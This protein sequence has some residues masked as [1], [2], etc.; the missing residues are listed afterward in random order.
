MTT[1]CSDPAGYPTVPGI[2]ATIAG[3]MLPQS[4][5][6]DHA[7]HCAIVG[8]S[9]GGFPPEAVGKYAVTGDNIAVFGQ[10][11]YA[12]LYLPVAHVDAGMSYPFYFTLDRA[13][14]CSDCKPAG[15]PGTL[16]SYPPVSGPGTC[17]MTV[18]QVATGG[19]CLRARFTC[20]GLVG[21]SSGESFDVTDG[22]VV[23]N[24]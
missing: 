19:G 11:A 5:V 4:L 1:V 7:V 18:D 6:L 20:T 13:S 14:G 3:G 16:A 8:D 23:C 15:Q 24:H 22:V 17:T 21:A 9:N 12:K 10:E 2:T